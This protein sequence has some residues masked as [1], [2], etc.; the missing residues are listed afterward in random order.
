MTSNNE[1][2]WR[3]QIKYSMNKNPKLE[4]KPWGIQIILPENMDR[5]E[6]YSIIEKHKSWIK[7]KTME[8]QEALERSRNIKLVKRSKAEF[9]NLVKKLLDQ[10]ARDELGINPCKVVI[11]KMKTRWASCS[12][13][14]VI[15]VNSLA[16]YLPDN[17]VLYIIYHEIC[18][19]IEPKH[20]KDF[21]TCVQ[22]YYPN[23]KELEK[24]LLAY[25]VKLLVQM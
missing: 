12:P 15:T 2:M 3:I 5:R 19:I 1:N 4:V 8:L 23:Y 20:N 11:R 13:K 9:K 22:K 21:W 7:K 25:E 14:G 6:A 10:V 18:H 16:R 17:L 24:E